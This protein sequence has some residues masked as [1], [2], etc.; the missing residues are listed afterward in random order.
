MDRIDALRLFVRVVETGS[1]SR[2]ARDLQVSQPT[3]TRQVAALE[4]GLRQRL[5]NRNTRRLSLTDAG[6]LY[7]E[8]AQLLLD[9]F[10]ETETLLRGPAGQLRGRLRVATSVAF[11]RRVVTPLVLTFMRAHP[12][13]QVDLSC[14]DAYVDIV[15]QGIDVSVRLGKLRD[16]ALAARHLGESPWVTVAGAGYSR[17]NGRP[18]R[19]ADLA[20]HNVLIYST[21]HGDDTLPYSHPRHGRVPVRVSGS[22]RSNSLSALLAAARADFGIAALPMYVVAASL[23]EGKVQPVLSDYAL[24]SQEIHAVFPSRRLIS[25]RVT[26]LVEHLAQAFARPDW[27]AG[28]A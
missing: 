22:L 7:Y 19:P 20:R 9:T 16:S 4:E 8:R 25:A 14:E 6:R 1:F 13:V 23:K 5:F 2:A 18:E 17:R 11:G 15:A 12:Q 26:A 28:M 27:Y 10:E 3:V 24:P 21:V